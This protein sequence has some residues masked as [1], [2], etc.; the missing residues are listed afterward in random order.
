M[1]PP[2]LD[3]SVPLDLT[4]LRLRAER[5]ILGPPPIDRHELGALVERARLTHR[6]EWLVHV[7]AQVVP[8]A[9]VTIPASLV[10][11]LDE[12]TARPSEYFLEVGVPNLSVVGQ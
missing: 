10:P 4:D 8:Q 11:L 1:P 6:L 7:L 12:I 5:T 9:P 3:L 2:D